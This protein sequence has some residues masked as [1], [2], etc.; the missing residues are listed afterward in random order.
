MNTLNLHFSGLNAGT[1]LKP[2]VSYVYDPT[3]GESGVYRPSTP[4]DMVG[5]GA[6]SLNSVSSGQLTG[7]GSVTTAQQRSQIF[8]QNVGTTPMFVALSGE[9]SPLN[10]HF[11]LNGGDSLEDG[12]GGSWTANNWNGPVSV[13][14]SGIAY[15][16]FEF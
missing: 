9:A 11:I 10:Y 13:S 1:N 2:V 12:N 6:S 5:G 7:I 8:L 16:Y 15:T 14:G 3:I 4:N